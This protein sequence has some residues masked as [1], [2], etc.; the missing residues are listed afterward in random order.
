MRKLFTFM[1]VI[2]MLASC[3]NENDNPKDIKVT[4][5][6]TKHEL[7]ADQTQSNE[8]IKFA[9]TGGWSSSISGVTRVSDASW[10]TISPSSG[11]QAGEYTINF[12][13]RPNDTG[14]SRKA[15]IKII[16]GSTTITIIVEQKEYTQAEQPSTA[17]VFITSAGKI[18][19][20]EIFNSNSTSYIEYL[21]T[22]VGTDDSGD[23][24]GIKAPYQNKNF[25]ITLPAPSIN[26]QGILMPGITVTPS[27]CK[28][29][30]A[31]LETDKGVLELNNFPNSM[32]DASYRLKKGDA[33]IVFIYASKSAIANGTANNN[34][35]N[36][37]QT[38]VFNNCSFRQG[39]NEMIAV[40]AENETSNRRVTFNI[41]T[42]SAN[43]SFRWR[44]DDNEIPAEKQIL[45][46]ARMEIID[47]Y[48]LNPEFNNGETK[49]NRAHN[50]MFE[51]DN[52]QR[53]VQ[54]TN[55]GAPF[56]SINYR[57]E[58]VDFISNIPM[59]NSIHGAK[60]ENQGT[61]KVLF[62]TDILGAG[63]YDSYNYEYEPNNN[64][65][66]RL[67]RE[68]KFNG[69]FR[70]FTYEGSLH[71]S[72]QRIVY[73]DANKDNVLNNSDRASVAEIEFTYGNTQ[74]SPL[75][76][77]EALIDLMPF[78]YIN[79]GSLN[80]IVPPSELFSMPYISNLFGTKI[81]VLPS[82]IT[83]SSAGYSFN[84]QEQAYIHPTVFT[85]SEV[86]YKY[87]VGAE[88]I[89]NLPT[90]IEITGSHTW[91][92]PSLDPSKNKMVANVKRTIN[93][94]YKNIN[95][96]NK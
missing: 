45:A 29:T 90:R 60:I 87:I 1:F 19:G 41:T 7:F 23:Y 24:P 69:V 20:G 64:W 68:L 85:N 33:S 21:F 12:T 49:I 73:N 63:L 71:N 65:P 26:V 4:S 9:T 84:I 80:C 75:F 50:L 81:P 66:I 56:Y 96:A 61:P 53:V 57:G 79:F 8:G 17:K 94:S 78:L 74:E 15:E 70:K 46:V 51:Y 39:W 38:F 43:S 11:D 18:T 88:N 3:S 52:H 72:M 82:K 6:S 62:H 14:K 58:T 95:A 10:L 77:N 89:K 47:N 42:N 86:T 48:T 30:T 34:F 13:H 59:V 93:I 54:V 16:C 92:D 2:C 35:E 25:Y 37:T 5:G 55:D 91:I 27:D 32:N 83:E 31:A 76:D 40:V 28:F 22:A 67:T 36:R 44:S